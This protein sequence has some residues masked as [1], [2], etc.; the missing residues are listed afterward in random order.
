MHVK[1][2]HPNYHWHCSYCPKGY[3]TYNAAYK[4]ERNH[5]AP[6]HICNTCQKAFHYK[7][8]LH[9]HVKLHTGEGLIPCIRCKKKFNTKSAMNAH[10]INHQNRSFDCTACS[11]S[12]TSL[13]YLKQHVQ[14]K[15][16][17]GGD[18]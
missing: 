10:A 17:G 16:R 14:G 4:H 11:K 7:S 5:S 15:H 3:A 18:L 12:F 13:E 8:Q 6:T 1:S 9:E 2:K